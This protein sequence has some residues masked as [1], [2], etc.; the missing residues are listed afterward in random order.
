[1][2]RLLLVLV[3]LLMSVAFSYAQSTQQL[4]FT[5]NGNNCVPGIQASASVPINVSSAT[6]TE[7]VALST[8]KRVYITSWD[9]IANGTVNVTLVYGTGTACATG[10]VALTG[11]Y[12]FIAQAGI[13][14]GN[15]TGIVLSV[16]VSQAVCIITSASPNFSGSLSY[17]QF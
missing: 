11:T 15:G 1:M 6:T 16:P 14:K 5:T 7:L 10:Q 4:C 3:T 13:A 8:G 12:R 2:K 17:V 9:G